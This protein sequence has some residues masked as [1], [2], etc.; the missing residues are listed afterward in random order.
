MDLNAELKD[1]LATY[2]LGLAD[3]ELILGHRNSEWCGHAPILEE[4]IAFANLALDELGHA[5][6][7]YGLLA[8]I[9]GEDPAT[10][11]DRL[12]YF[13]D[14]GQYRNLQM[15]ELP[16]GDW[17][18]S[19]LRQYLFDAA[20]RVRLEQ[21]ERS[22]YVPLAAAA[23][24]IRKEELYHLRHSQAWVKRLGRGTP[25]SRQRLQ[26][27]LQALWPFTYQ[28]FA[29]HHGLDSLAEAGLAPSSSRLQ[30]DWKAQVIALLGESELDIPLEASQ[31]AREIPGRDEHTSHLKVLL[32]DMQFLARSEPEAG[33]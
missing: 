28:L 25:E 27:A 2:L 5:L 4:D 33:W 17:A 13:R 6:I 11:P 14:A 8:D 3:D 21:L 20:E 9:E 32:T 19:I 1:N 12:V 15:V 10:Y 29:S 24:K 26:I 16:N 31:P 23:G 30:A 22:A 7:W 18:F